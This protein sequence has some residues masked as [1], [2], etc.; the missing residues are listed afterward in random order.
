MRRT[1]TVLRRLMISIVLAMMLATAA[2]SY[3]SASNV[4]A[5]DT[6]CVTVAEMDSLFAGVDSLILERRLLQ[7]DL[8][9]ARQRA[10]VDSVLFAERLALRDQRDTWFVRALKHPVMDAVYFVLGVYI[11]ANAIS[12][13]R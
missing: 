2:P 3:D 10:H 4:F 12:Q 11:G 6:V 9:E 13:V 7:I 8:R 5:T 1:K